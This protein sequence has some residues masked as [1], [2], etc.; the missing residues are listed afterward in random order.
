M[1]TPKRK[2][3]QATLKYSFKDALLKPREKASSTTTVTPP[4]AGLATADS[5]KERCWIFVY[6]SNIWIVAKKLQSRLKKFKT[7]EDHRVRIDMGKLGDVLANGRTIVKGTLYGSEPPR[8][9]TVWKKIEE[10]GWKVEKRQRDEISGKEKVH[11]KLVTDVVEVAFKTPDNE[12]STIILV[13]G[14]A[15]IIPAIEVIFDNDKYWKIEVYMWNQA[16]SRKFNPTRDKY[17]GRLKIE[18]LDD[19]IDH[20][21]FTSM[22]FNTSNQAFSTAIHENGVVFVMEPD[23]FP[24]HVPTYDWV[25]Q[26]E[27]IAKWPFQYYWLTENDESKTNNLV[28]VFRRDEKAGRFN[29]AKFLKNLVPIT[30]STTQPYHIPMVQRAVPFEEF[31]EELSEAG[32]EEETKPYFNFEQVGSFTREHVYQGFHNGLAYY[33]DSY[34]PGPVYHVVMP[35]IEWYYAFASLQ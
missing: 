32:K 7:G 11:T 28:I 29:I 33:I 13:T 20:V 21:T 6:D 23:A 18:K 1:A 17:A 14:D 27:T 10:R 15:D 25:R 35:I 3:S 26:L 31:E 19:Y 16:I 12:K 34:K 5:S 2:S 9:D 30:H 24:D 8:I 4:K 22:K